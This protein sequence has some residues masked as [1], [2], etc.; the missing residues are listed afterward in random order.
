MHLHYHKSYQKAVQK[1][2]LQSKGLAYQAV[3]DFKDNPKSPGLNFERLH[4]G[5]FC[6]IRASRDLR[7]ILAPLEGDEGANWLL[8]YVD[9]HEDAYGWARRTRLDYTAAT[10]TYDLLRVIGE[11][12]EV[13]AE[14]NACGD[15]Q[16]GAGAPIW[17]AWSDEQLMEIGVKEVLMVVASFGICQKNTEYSV[18]QISL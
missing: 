11:E 16:Q 14:N 8:V 18:C 7:I 9:H 4:A 6:S 10:Q 2:D 17:Q 15:A 1:L 12:R 13:G 3:M 5:D